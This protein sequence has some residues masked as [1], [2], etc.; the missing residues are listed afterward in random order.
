[1]SNTIYLNGNFQTSMV[2][3]SSNI[4][5]SVN[6]VMT[7]SNATSDMKNIALTATALNTSSLSDLRYFAANNV[8]TASIQIATDA[9]MTNIISTLQP[10]DSVIIPWSAS[11]ASIPLYAK[12]LV[13]TSVLSYIVVES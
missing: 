2:G 12:S 9:A 13:Y 6:V 4:P 11:I 8:G 3:G 7:G 10:N 1:M 5:I